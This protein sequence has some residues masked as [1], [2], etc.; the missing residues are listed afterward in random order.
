MKKTQFAPIYPMSRGL[1]KTSIPGTQDP[2]SL[3]TAKNIVLRSKPSIKKRPGLRRIPYIGQDDGTQAVTQFIATDGTNQ[4]IEIVRARKGRLE[5]LRQNTS[6]SFLDLGVSFSDTDTVTFERVAN[7]L[8]IFFENSPPL[9][10]SIGGTPTTLDILSSHLTSPPSF[11]RFHDFRLWYS[12]RPADPHRAW[13]SAINNPFDY[14]LLGGAFSLRV[15][16]GDGDPVGVTGISEPFRGDIYFYKWNSVQRIFASDYGY[17]ISQITDEVGAIHHNCIKTTANDIYSVA[18]D[19]IHSLSMTDKYG[20]AE[21]ATVTYPIY[22]YFQENINWANYKNMVLAYDPK[23]STLLLSYTSA[24]SSVT[25]RVLGFNTISKEFFE[26]ENCEYPSMFKFFDVQLTHRLA[27]ADQE[28][29][30]CIVDDK[31]NTLDGDPID[32]EIETGVI[33]PMGNPKVEVTFTQA[34]LVC[35]PT[36]DS[37]DVA[38][39]YSLDGNQYIEATV[40]TLTEGYGSTIKDGKQGIDGGIIGTDI[41]G[42]MKSD[43]IVLPFDCV[44][45]AASISFRIKQEPMD[46]D[47]DQSCEIYGIIYEYEYNEDTTQIVKI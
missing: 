6:D 38:I 35:K 12:G 1:D 47:A 45:D 10:Y 18:H 21:A 29:G 36:N 19:G 3:V 13:A 8:V 15:R 14:T 17:G 7:I 28:R 44:G 9:Y 39:A 41:I 43:M 33:F 22:E 16:D 24:G 31:E 20:A 37:V 4:R 26:W 11:G 42:K 30:I 40:N 32:L 25:D 27:V 23:T 34:W 46:D 2:K 5:V